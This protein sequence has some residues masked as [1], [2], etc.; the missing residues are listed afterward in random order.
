MANKGASSGSKTPGDVVAEIDRLLAPLSADERTRALAAVSALHG[1]APPGAPAAVAP[2]A[3]VPAGT[4]N[5]AVSAWMKMNGLDHAMVAAVFHVDDGAAEVIG[6]IAGAT[7]KERTINTYLLAGVCALLGSGAPKFAEAD[8]VKLC[9]HLGCH[10]RGNHANYRGAAG[11]AL[12]GSRE[13]GWTLTAPGLRRAAE[14]VK[15][16]A[17]AGG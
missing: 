17:G 6:G 7:E 4:P 16:M 10:N 15:E 3:P 11:K 12:V 14:L 8:A 5:A 1:A 2:A 13:K 9:K